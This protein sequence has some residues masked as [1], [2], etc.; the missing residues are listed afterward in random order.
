MLETCIKILFAS[1][2][3]LKAAS[4]SSWGLMR[5]W[6]LVSQFLW[7]QFVQHGARSCG[8]SGFRFWVHISSPFLGPAILTHAAEVP[9]LGPQCGPQFRAKSRAL[10]AL[11]GRLF[12]FFLRS[13]WQQWSGAVNVGLIGSGSRTMKATCSRTMTPGRRTAQ[14]SRYNRWTFA[15]AW[16][17][18]CISAPELGPFSGCDLGVQTWRFLS[19]MGR[20]LATWVC[21]RVRAVGTPPMHRAQESPDPCSQCCVGMQRSEFS[22]RLIYNFNVDCRGRGRSRKQFFAT[23]FKKRIFFPKLVRKFQDWAQPGGI[24]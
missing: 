7:P 3:R 20:E 12:E 11:L 14:R 18:R 19:G 15:R 23:S 8:L 6:E 21:E 22:E 16:K 1:L 9:F 24:E 13:I 10:N 17:R 2:V 5:R 4:F